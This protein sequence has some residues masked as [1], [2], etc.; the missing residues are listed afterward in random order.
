VVSE[1]SRSA[2][3]F[4]GA[5]CLARSKSRL[6]IAAA[7]LG[8]G[9]TSGASAQAWQPQ[10]NV[11]IVVGSAPGGINDRTARTI[12]KVLSD[13]KLVNAPLVVINRPGG[14]GNISFNYVDQRR[15]DPHYLLMGTTSMLSN[16]IVGSS[17]LGHND[18]TPIA[19][20]LSDYLVFVVQP[21]SPIKSARELAEQL[22]KD[23]KSLTI[24]FANTIG[25]HNHIAAGMMLK[26]M[27]GNARDLKVVV[28]KG[29]ADAFAALLGGHIDVI[30]SAGGNAAPHIVSGKLRGIGVT[31]DKRYA[32]A[33]AHIPT[34]KEQG[35]NVVTGGWR[36]LM[37]PKGLGAQHIAYWEGVLRALTETADWKG[38][39]ERNFSADEFLTGEAF[40]QRLDS[41]YA[42]MKAVLADLGLTK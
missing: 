23:P 19:S 6:L 42:E 13:N 11:E 10:K 18:F 20:L 16:H 17:K 12:E 31:A 5:L 1:N 3:A 26:A 35:L 25:N 39:L 7:A 14:G 27:G 36:A 28:F 34:L 38:Y 8:F 40:K 33:L 21:Q 37:G 32:G 41:D 4:S 29:S 22:R 24:G 15:S 9:V 2:P 30:P